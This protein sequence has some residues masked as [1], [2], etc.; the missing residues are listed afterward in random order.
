MKTLSTLLLAT[1]L[2]AGGAVASAPAFAADQMGTGALRC[3]TGNNQDL[4][5]QA[6]HQLAA[7]LQLRTKLAPTIEEWNGC[8]KVQYTDDNGHTVVALYDPDSLALVNKL[9]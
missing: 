8:F 9:S 6:K 4:I 3:D 1:T 2:L 5:N 7:Q